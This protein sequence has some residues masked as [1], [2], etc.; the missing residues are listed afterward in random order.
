MGQ[1]AGQG[2]AG[3]SG[4]GGVAQPVGYGCDRSRGGEDPVAGSHERVAMGGRG[5]GAEPAAP[6]GRAAVGGPS[7]RWSRIQGG[8]P[9]LAPW[10]FV[11]L[12][13][14]G[15]VGAKYGLPDAGPFSFLFVRMQIAWVLLAGLAIAT[16]AT[17]PRTPGAAAHLAVAGLLLHAGYLG[18]VFYAIGRGMPAGLAALIVGLQPVLTAVGAQALLRER[19]AGRRWVGLGLG[20]VG[21]ALVVGE[22]VGAAGEGSIGVG[23][24]AAVGLALVATTAGTLYQKRFGGGADLTAGAAIQ[25]LAAGAALAPLALV[26]GMRID[27][28]V[29]FVLALGWLVLGLSLGAMLLLLALIRQHAVSRVAGLLYLVPPA[30]AIEA[31]VLFGERLGPLALVGMAVVAVG[32]A[33]VVREPRGEGSG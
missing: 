10:L 20:F 14:T 26:E 16:R 22:Q 4:G 19:V 29:P 23:A 11:A 15:F 31:Y 8:L 2:E 17:W 18:G 3:A 1:G 12:W 27:W 32:V 33:L 25:Y 6:G 28:T 30:T 13:S 5:D 9:T 21:V 7:G 24:F